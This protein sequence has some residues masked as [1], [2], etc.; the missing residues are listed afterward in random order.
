MLTACYFIHGKICINES[1]ICAHKTCQP[2]NESTGKLL[3]CP[4]CHD[5]KILCCR[6]ATWKLHYH[7]LWSEAPHFEPADHFTDNFSIVIGIQWQ[8]SAVL[9]F[10]SCYCINTNFCTCHESSDVVSC[11]KFCRNHLIGHVGNAKPKCLLRNFTNFN[12]IYKAHQ[13]NVWWTM[14]VFR[15]H[16]WP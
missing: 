9:Q 8:K 13:T 12:R 5:M 3:L 10:H 7:C 4:W 15:L 16:Y 6:L 1:H 2:V 11:A 14:K